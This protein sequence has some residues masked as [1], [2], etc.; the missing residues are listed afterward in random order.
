MLWIFL[1]AALTTKQTASSKIKRSLC[2]PSWHIGIRYLI[3]SIVLSLLKI[4][5]YV[6]FGCIRWNT[7]AMGDCKHMCLTVGFGKFS[8]T[9]FSHSISE[10]L[11]LTYYHHHVVALWKVSVKT[12]TCYSNISENFFSE[13]L[14]LILIYEDHFFHPAVSSQDIGLFDFWMYT[15]RYNHDG[16]QSLNHPV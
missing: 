1:L 13:C 14:T 4:P 8:I 3:L 16:R 12:F 9:L 6:I 15:F 7:I 10:W 2:W 5:V 11:T